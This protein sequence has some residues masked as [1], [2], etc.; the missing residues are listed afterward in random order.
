MLEG[1]HCLQEQEFDRPVA[2]YIN[3][4]PEA[5]SIDPATFSRQQHALMHQLIHTLVIKLTFNSV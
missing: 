4:C 1:G 2:G 3:F 5:L